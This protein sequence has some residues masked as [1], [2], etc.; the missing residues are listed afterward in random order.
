MSPPETL[1]QIWDDMSASQSRWYFFT[2]ISVVLFVILV[3]GI[4]CGRAS[5][6]V[7]AEIKNR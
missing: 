4:F 7:A 1:K 2:V 5:K 6:R 3:V